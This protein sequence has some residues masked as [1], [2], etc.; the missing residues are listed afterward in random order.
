M[1][2]VTSIRFTEINGRWQ[3]PLGS[4]A[5]TQ[6]CVDYGVTLRLDQPAGHFELR[7]EQALDFVAADG[8]ASSLDPEEDP[9]G[10]APLLACTRT[11]ATAKTA[12][13]DGR[14]EMSFADGSRISVSASDDYEAWELAGPSGLRMVSTPGRHVTIWHGDPEN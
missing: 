14:L 5:V 11:T 2:I 7:I 4:C 8:A 3:L 9:T 1:A 13:Q 10:L 12:F 6:C